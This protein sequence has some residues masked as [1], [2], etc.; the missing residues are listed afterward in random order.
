MFLSLYYLREQPC[1]E[2]QQLIRLVLTLLNMLPLHIVVS[3][4][5][6][7]QEHICYMFAEGALKSL[8]IKSYDLSEVSLSL[9]LFVSCQV[10]HK[11]LVVRVM[12]ALGQGA[13]CLVNVV[14][15]VNI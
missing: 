7:G 8:E 2:L 12:R 6:T 11:A 1:E 10:G 3:Q 15:V 4:G 13:T 9:I 14:K 5:V